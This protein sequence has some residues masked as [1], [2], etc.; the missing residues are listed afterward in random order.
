M[1]SRVS[2]TML[3]EHM[4]TFEHGTLS[5]RKAAGNVSI[6][7]GIATYRGWIDKYWTTVILGICL[8][9]LAALTTACAAEPERK[10]VVILHSFG[11]DFRPW[12]EY[13]KTI[14]ME[15]TKQSRWP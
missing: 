6:D 12:G 15:L 2:S 9:Q 1:P 11:Q 5:R 7:Q 14:R 4:G 8:A 3:H 13:A 10:Q